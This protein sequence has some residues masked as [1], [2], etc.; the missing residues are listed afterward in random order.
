MKRWTICLLACALCIGLAAAESEKKE[1]K[2]EKKEEKKK[3]EKKPVV[4][5]DAVSKAVQARCKDAQVESAKEKKENDKVCY[6]VK[7]KGK[8][9]ESCKLVLAPDGKLVEADK[10]V[11]AADALPAAVADAAKKWAPG[12]VI[13]KVEVETKKDSGTCYKVEAALNGKNIKA[14]I[15]EDGKVVKADKLPEAKPAKKEEKKEEK[16][17]E[18]KK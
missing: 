5:P 4:L 18:E 10:C 12:A 16:K 15:A 3:E 14:E 13:G 11:I 2:E 6:E 7:V 9:G 17:K 1:K 8:C